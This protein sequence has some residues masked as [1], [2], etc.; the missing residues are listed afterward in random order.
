MKQGFCSR[1]CSRKTLGALNLHKKIVIRRSRPFV[2][3]I[4][5][6]SCENR[7][8]D[9]PQATYKL[10]D[11]RSIGFWERVTRPNRAQSP[12]FSLEAQRREAQYQMLL[13][14]KKNKVLNTSLNFRTERR[15]KYLKKYL[16]SFLC[17][18][19]VISLL[20]MFLCVRHVR[21]VIQ[22][23]CQLFKILV[24]VSCNVGQK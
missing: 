24:T 9:G 23:I 1:G 12:R 11:R 6:K 3:P 20:H 16:Y 19:E 13:V 17:T 22:K 21:L 2:R 7:K 5:G 15:L 18:K 8:S 10:A 4:K 14:T